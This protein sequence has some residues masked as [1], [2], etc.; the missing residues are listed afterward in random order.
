MRAGQWPETDSTTIDRYQESYNDLNALLTTAHL[1]CL[2]ECRPS[3][4]RSSLC[5]NLYSM[6]EHRQP[7]RRSRE[8]SPAPSLR[9]LLDL[10]LRHRAPT[11]RGNTSVQTMHRLWAVVG[12]V[13]ISKVAA[14]TSLMMLA[15]S[16]VC[17]VLVLKKMPSCAKQMSRRCC[18]AK[19]RP[20]ARDVQRELARCDL[21]P[22]KA[23]LDRRPV[24]GLSQ[25]YETSIT[26]WP[27]L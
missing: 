27:S 19:G 10:K 13:Y 17:P 26:H 15:M 1:L 23:L 12:E 5:R 7:D 18:K 21:L 2:Q 16:S 24:L 8:A 14:G 22:R 20:L 11:S 9:C 4:S 6:L 25:Q 3:W